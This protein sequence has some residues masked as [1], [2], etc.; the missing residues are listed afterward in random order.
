[1]DGVQRDEEFEVLLAE[2]FDQCASSQALGVPRSN[3]PGMALSARNKRK[4]IKKALTLLP[5]SDAQPLDYAVGG[6]GALAPRF[7]GLMLLGGW[8]MITIV[9]SLV[10]RTFVAVGALPMLAVFFGVNHPRAVLLTDRGAALLKCGFLN[11]RPTELIGTDVAEAV[12]RPGDHQAG[13]TRIHL[14]GQHIWLRDKDL[15]RLAAMV[16]TSP[17]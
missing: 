6:G 5:P 7:L 4:H 10:L 11:G 12:A 9:L 8:V 17:S 16:T 1:M 2:Q 13:A 14:G 3:L 15:A